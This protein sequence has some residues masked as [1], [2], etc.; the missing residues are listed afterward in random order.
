VTCGS[1]PFGFAQDGLARDYRGQGRSHQPDRA[2]VADNCP[3]AGLWRYSVTWAPTSTT[4]F[5]GS[6]KKSVA[7]PALRNMAMKIRSRQ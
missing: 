3:T 4:R 2:C 5:G 1:E 6:R 7:L